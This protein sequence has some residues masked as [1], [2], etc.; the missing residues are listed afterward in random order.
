[1]KK[2]FLVIS[3]GLLVL[4]SACNNS[5]ESSAT[6]TDTVTNVVTDTIT[7]TDTVVKVV[8]GAPAIVDSAAIIR[9][10]L[11]EQ[12][13]EKKTEPPKPK[14]QGTHEVV[15]YS[16][17]TIRSHEAIE[18]PQA[19][20]TTEYVY[21][22]PTERAKFPGGLPAGQEFIK[23]NLVYPEDALTYHVEGTVYA[24]MYLDSIGNVTAVEFPGKHLGMG[25]EEET[26]R[27][28]MM[29]PRWIPAKE[30]GIRVKSKVTV[31]VVYKITK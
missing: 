26:H 25:L 11:A 14:K 15:M 23:K 31:P 13:K 20:H 7:K 24:D 6:T 21:F 16:T 18:Q 19:K 30:N 3:G 28:L 5:G 17:E 1:M 27:V 8:E 10:Y 12:E 22:A 2:Q 29:S 4:L 9:A